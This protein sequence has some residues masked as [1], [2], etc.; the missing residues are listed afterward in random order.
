MTT[1][2][3]WDEDNIGGL[4]SEC[5]ATVTFEDIATVSH[6]GTVTPLGGKS[7]GFRH[8]YGSWDQP[9]FA[10]EDEYKARMHAAMFLYLWHKSVGLPLCDELACA[11][12]TQ[13]FKEK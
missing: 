7:W 5:E 12:V 11:Y 4:L 1:L 8:K 9:Y 3:D 6:D 13:F 2:K 10:Q